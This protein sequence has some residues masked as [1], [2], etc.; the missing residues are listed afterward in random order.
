MLFN[1]KRINTM[2]KR[3]KKSYA[4]A[5]VS[6]YRVDESLVEIHQ[7]QSG[8]VGIFR[9]LEDSRR[10]L[11]DHNG[12][13]QSLFEG[14][15]VMLAF[16]NR[17]AT[18][19]Y[20]AYVPTQPE[21]F[22]SLAGFGGIAGVISSV[23]AT[24]KH[25]PLPL[26]LIGYAVDEQGTVINTI[27]QTLLEPF[28]GKPG[29][30]QVILSVGSSMDSGK[31]TTAAYLCAGLERAGLTTAYIK[32]TGTAYPK[33]T[34]YVYDR[35]ASYVSSFSALGYPTTYLLPI[36]EILDIYQTLR[37]QAEAVVQPDYIV[38]EIADG[39][40]QQETKALLTNRAFMST[41]THTVLS[42]ADSLG[43][44][45][46][47]QLL[48]DFGINPL[49][50]SGLFTASEL[51]VEEVLSMVPSPIARLPE[52]LNASFLPLLSTERKLLR[53]VAANRA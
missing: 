50:I 42:C 25:E 46:A 7:P 29:T 40:L 19:Q 44:L 15:L 36:P 10:F 3:I 4:C 45:S 18:S 38:I 52:L 51:L 16:G 31:T 20:E 28:E 22:C 8:E 23:N 32:L 17:Y 33:D 43:V 5:M 21:R 41:V 53:A 13:N 6:T 9:V 11:K 14:D 35:G 2:E 47:H 37:T 49:L 1:K 48:S 34:Q 12:G 26:E 39:L 30:A 27:Q 24:M